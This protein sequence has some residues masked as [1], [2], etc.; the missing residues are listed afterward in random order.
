MI[1]RLARQ[2]SATTGVQAIGVISSTW[3]SGSL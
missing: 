3:S 1:A 2:A